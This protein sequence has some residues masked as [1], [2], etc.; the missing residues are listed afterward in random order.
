[1]YISSLKDVTKEWIDSIPK[2]I[3]SNGCWSPITT[4]VNKDYRQINIQN[5]RYLLHRLVMCLYYNIDY[6]N[7]KIDTRHATNCS[8]ECFFYEH[9]KPGNRSD[10]SKDAIK[11]GNHFQVNKKCCPK[12]GHEF[13]K[14]II[15]TGPN[16]GRSIRF[17][18][19]CKLEGGRNWRRENK[20]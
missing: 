18:H 10:N 19:P 15:K 20:K 12:C 9:L 11:D 17:C 13:T 8:L 7:Y 3:N 16:R 1:M 4:A 6:F 2:T 5:K 14:S